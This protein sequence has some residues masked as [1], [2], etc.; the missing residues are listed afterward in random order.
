MLRLSAA[1]LL[2][3]G[4]G[5][6]A[7][8]PASRP[9]E[10]V[11]VPP[12]KKIAKIRFFTPRLVQG[13]TLDV[14]VEAPPQPASQPSLPRAIL[15]VQRPGTDLK[16]SV[17]VVFEEIEGRRPSRSSTRRSEPL[18]YSG[19][20]KIDISKWPDGEVLVEVATPSPSGDGVSLQPA[21]TVRIIREQVGRIAAAH[22]DELATWV[23]TL[24]YFEPIWGKVPLWPN[25]DAALAAP[26]N[27]Y[28]DL[29]GF[30]V[31]SYENPQLLRRQPYTLYVPKSLDLSKPAP[32]LILLH[33]SGGD[34]RNLVADAAAGQR[35]ETDPMLIANAGA[36]RYQEYRHLALNDI[37]G[38]L[39]DVASK[40]NVDRNRVYLQGISLG[41]RGTL[42][43]AALM[44]D[45]F[46][47]VSAHGVY[48]IQM[49]WTDPPTILRRDA[50]SAW[51]SARSDFRTWIGNLRNV[52]AEIVFGWKDDTT[53]PVNAL[54]FAAL[55]RRVGGTAIERG[56]DTDHNISIP[57]Y[58][59][60]TTRQWFLQHSRNNA[61]DTIF[62][63]VANLRFNRGG[64]IAVNALHDYSRIG[65]VVAKFDS[66]SNL[67]T[68]TTDNVALLK[69]DQHPTDATAMSIN[70]AAPV[71]IERLLRLTPDGKIDAAP[72]P[73]T[74]PVATK[75][76][77]QSGPIWD[78]FSEPVV[79]VWGTG[80]DE[81]TTARL[82][83]SAQASARWDLAFGDPS[84]PCCSDAQVTARQRESA[85][86]VLFTTPGGRASKLAENLDIPW[87]AER[88]TAP[89]T[90]PTTRPAE[91][92]V[93]IALRP[94]PFAADRYVLVV[95]LSGD[96]PV[97]LHEV[98]WWDR[99]FQADWL[100]GVARTG[101]DR[102]RGVQI[103][104]AGVY[105]HE[106]RLGPWTRDDIRTQDLLGPGASK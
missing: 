23:D 26:H 78:V 56:F 51:L 21:Q 88:M 105:D 19:R 73:A 27:P 30:V 1:I 22:R 61:P 34:W 36:F 91:P 87:P 55:L 68:I 72:P 93:R 12:Q 89:T 54:L 46:A 94:S 16:T 37:R 95:E 9:A 103:L 59:W 5:F 39:D 24:S 84:L 80:G 33:G 20:A 52:P 41:G 74:Q 66:K 83:E 57:A 71:P 4:M 85:N 6:A 29:R 58:D 42:E 76:P 47:A 10:Y 14:L 70:G 2:F 25:L 48:G 18:L 53:P 28:S 99:A 92:D 62:L 75:R 35:F 60:A 102:A 65:Q 64:W 96:R 44:P 15:T 82:R 97:S 32:L 63:R 90:Q 8:P 38:V 40:Y 43:A 101:R 31:R 13:S 3:A 45:T 106:W 69:L 7:T 79:Y 98:G 86:L 77:N 67:V 100:A 104:A 17:E 49:P 11:G 50:T 81:A